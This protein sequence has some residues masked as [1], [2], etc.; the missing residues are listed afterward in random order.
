M[1]RQLTDSRLNR[2]IAEHLEP[3]PAFKPSRIRELPDGVEAWWFDWTCDGWQPR[4]F[5]T[6]PA[7]IVMLHQKLLDR[8]FHL[9]TWPKEDGLVTAYVANGLGLGVPIKITGPLGRAVAI[10]YA[11]SEKLTPPE[12]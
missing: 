1:I 8:G 10:A 9:T 3:S 5:V 6:D 4:D 7:L 11:V 2:L 12:P